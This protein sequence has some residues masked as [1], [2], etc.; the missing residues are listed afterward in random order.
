MVTIIGSM[1]DQVGVSCM[2]DGDS[3]VCGCSCVGGSSCVHSHVDDVSYSMGW[4]QPH[5]FAA[6]ACCLV[7][8]VGVVAAAMCILL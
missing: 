5:V 2:C 8:A 1:G 3:C 6:V 4:C 7:S